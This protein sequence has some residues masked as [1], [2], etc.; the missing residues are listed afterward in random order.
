MT[1]DFKA[2]E[3]VDGWTLVEELDK[4]GNGEVWVATRVDGTTVAVKFLKGKFQDAEHKR[5]L[6]FRDE[7]TQHRRLAGLLQGILPFVDCSLPET[8]TREAPAWLA[9]PVATVIQKALKGRPL[10]DAVETV[11]SIAETLAAMHAEGVSHRDVKPKNLF[12]YEGRWVVGDLGLVDYPDKESL[13]ET[14]ERLGP[15]HYLAPEMMDEAKHADGR[16]ADVY[17][18]GK[19]FWVVATEQNVPPPGEMRADVAQLHIA[20]YRPHPRAHQLDLLIEQTTRHDPDARPTM[21]EVAKELRAWLKEPQVKPPGNLSDLL[22]GVRTAAAAPPGKEKERLVQ[23]FHQAFAHLKSSLEGI[24]KTLTGTGLSNGKVY[25]NQGGSG[26]Y[27]R[28]PPAC[29]QIRGGAFLSGEV[30]CVAHCPLTAFEQ[31]N[32]VELICEIGLRVY[33]DGAVYLFGGHLVRFGPRRG[34]VIGLKDWQGTLG[35][36]SQDQAVGAI[37]TSLNENLNGALEALAAEIEYAKGLPSE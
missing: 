17:S 21:A 29:Q 20:A 6:R 28:Q 36:A 33:P 12:E 1:W 3:T 4:G 22:A 2:G 18:L 5:Y 27:L 19:T 37:L 23:S 10:H 26:G 32:D 11:A 30:Y 31:S 16:K 34:K 15:Y 9:T 24:A 14:G 13:T 7:V 35:S 25:S 8:P